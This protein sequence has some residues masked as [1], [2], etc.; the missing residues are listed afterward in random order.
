LEKQFFGVLKNK[1]QKKY[2]TCIE[3]PPAQP[4]GAVLG[5]LSSH[6]LGGCFGF[7]TCSRS[8]LLAGQYV[9]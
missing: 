3:N 8:G 1:N 6:L 5:A 7:K 9:C 4:S 2:A